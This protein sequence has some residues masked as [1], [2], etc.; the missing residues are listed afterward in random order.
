MKV[1][2]DA[3]LAGKRMLVW[4]VSLS[5][6]EEG[7]STQPALEDKPSAEVNATED[8]SCHAAMAAL[9]LRFVL[10]RVAGEASLG[11]CSAP[12]RVPAHPLEVG[13]KLG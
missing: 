3:Q 10:A 8:A 2:R 9:E 13:C 5:Q 4:H 6:T 11:V 7:L 12:R 1:E